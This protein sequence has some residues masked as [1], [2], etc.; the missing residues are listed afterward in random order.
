MVVCRE[1]WVKSRGSCVESW[2]KSWVINCAK[3]RV[4]TLKNVLP[5][6]IFITIHLKTI[7][8]RPFAMFLTE[9]FK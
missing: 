8:V 2:V 5:K 9:T 3:N 7:D 4:F 6:F 1:S